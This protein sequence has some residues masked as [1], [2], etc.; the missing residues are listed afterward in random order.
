[1]LDIEWKKWMELLRST[2]QA[3]RGSGSSLEKRLSELLELINFTFYCGK[4]RAE[5]AF[6]FLPFIAIFHYKNALKLHLKGAKNEFG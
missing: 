2:I 4:L 5:F 3:Q 1:M 6:V